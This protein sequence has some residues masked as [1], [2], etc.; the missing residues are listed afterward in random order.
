[1]SFVHLARGLL[2]VL[3]FTAFTAIM[4]TASLAQQA[5]PA[6]PPP[7]QAAAPELVPLPVQAFGR[8]HLTCLEWSDNCVV[9]QRDDTGATHCST[10]AIACLSEDVVC[11]R[12]KP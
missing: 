10:T 9:C 11:R 4:P 12:E 5:P 3:A 8:D 7:T 1:M 2:T 6:A